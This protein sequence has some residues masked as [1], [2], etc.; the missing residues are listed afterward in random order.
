[1]RAIR[2]QDAS[3]A[4]GAFTFFRRPNSVTEEI[5]H[6]AS[7]DGSHVLFWAGATLVDGTFD[8]VT[9]M[10]PAELR[11]LAKDLPPVA[12]A[13]NV[14]PSLPA[15]LPR[16]GLE[17]G[18]SHYSLGPESYARS[19]G[20]LPGA[21]VDFAGTS[22]EAITAYYSN[23]DG[24][25]QLTLLLYPTPQLA[26]ARLHAIEDFLKAGNSQS[27]WPQPLAESPAGSVLT[28]RSGP[29]IAITSGNLPAGTAKKLLNKV[30]YQA[31]VVWNDPKGYISDGSKIARLM[32]GIITLAGILCGAA[33][34]LA[35]FL[36]GGRALF[37]VAR[38]KPAS[39]FD[40]QNE[41]IRLNL[42]D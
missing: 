28:R 9:P 35:I 3:G 32:V 21:L 16:E 7:W 8:R 24:N 14:P 11:E 29:I 34:L 36:G 12:G 6:G 19:G 39:A 13:A 30:N 33:L 37:R 18:P 22:A 2:C 1:V 38:G 40:E 15:Y 27:S 31:D 10:S 42:E 4:F 26:G 25:G 17:L 5:G 41:I 20:V 23:R